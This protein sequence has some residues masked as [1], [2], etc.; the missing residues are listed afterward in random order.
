MCYFILVWFHCPTPINVIQVLATPVAV[1]LFPA[2]ELVLLAPYP[3]NASLVITVGSTP[4]VLPAKAPARL[5]PYPSKANLV[6]AAATTTLL[7]AN[8]PVPLAP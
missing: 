5:A 1:L 3:S 7:P 4:V 8:E 2:K 6:R